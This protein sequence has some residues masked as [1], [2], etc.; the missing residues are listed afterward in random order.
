M[1]CE[2]SL[3][4]HVMVSV[5]NR[6]LGHLSVPR[7]TLAGSMAEFFLPQIFVEF[8]F[9]IYIFLFPSFNYI[10]FLS[11]PMALPRPHLSQTDC[12]RLK[13][14][15]SQLRP[16]SDISGLSINYTREKRDESYPSFRSPSLPASLF[17]LEVRPG[18]NCLC[19]WEKV[20][21]PELTCRDMRSWR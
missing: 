20:L 15:T 19:S 7:V 18:D 12:H 2:P 10:S 17:L 3:P 16:S 8:E 9:Y 1:L 11:L 21:S 13:E 4:P 6:A 14:K 5:Q